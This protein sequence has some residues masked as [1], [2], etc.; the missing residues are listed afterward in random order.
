MCRSARSPA[1][2]WAENRRLNLASRIRICS[3]RSVGSVRPCR[4][5]ARAPRS[6]V[7]LRSRRRHRRGRKLY[8]SCGTEDEVGGLIDANQALLR[9]L[10][11]RDVAPVCTWMAGRHEWPVWR[12]SLEE[13][14][15]FWF[16]RPRD[17]TAAPVRRFQKLEPFPVP[18][19]LEV[20]GPWRRAAAIRTS[21]STAG[22]GGW[23][24]IITGPTRNCR[25]P[26]DR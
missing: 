5:A 17:A 22:P 9:V 4:I 20:A 24:R 11:A 18:S 25:S 10:A 19:A 14:L 2:R 6:T 21:R 15:R 12:R 8:C 26:A 3:S 23:L 7:S 16:Q 1:C 13:F